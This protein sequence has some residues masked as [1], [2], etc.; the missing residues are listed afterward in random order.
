MLARLVPTELRLH[1]PDGEIIRYAQAEG[2]LQVFA[3]QA[4]VLVG[5]CVPPEQLDEQTL[6]SRL[7]DAESRMKEAE[8]GTAAFERAER[9]MRRAQAFLSVATLLSSGLPLT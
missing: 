2:W 7:E 8:E 6:Q 5:E 4:L 9:D 1:K 3:N